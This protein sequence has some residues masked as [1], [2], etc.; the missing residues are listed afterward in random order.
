MIA[1]YPLIDWRSKKVEGK[2]EKSV[3]LSYPEGGP[4]LTPLTFGE[5]KEETEKDAKSRPIKAQPKQ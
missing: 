4:I 3:Y 1:L 2:G 5:K